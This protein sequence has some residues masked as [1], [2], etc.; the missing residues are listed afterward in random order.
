MIQIVCICDCSPSIVES[1]TFLS[2]SFP[3]FFYL[4]SCISSFVQNKEVVL[5]KKKERSMMVL[6]TRA[7]AAAALTF[8]ALLRETTAFQGQKAFGLTRPT[9]SLSRLDC[10]RCVV[11][12]S[13][14][15]GLV[16]EACGW[17]S[18]NGE[19][20]V[21]GAR[22]ARILSPMAVA[23]AT[24]LS[25]I[26]SAMAA[27]GTFDQSL[28][29]YFPSAL[30]SRKV[31]SKVI[32]TLRDRGFKWDNTV[33]ASSVCSDEINVINES[34]KCLVNELQ[35]AFGDQSFVLG[36]LG[37][38]PFVGKS[39]LGACVSHVPDEGKLLI[40]FAPHVG[41]SADGVVG[42]IR[43][44]NKAKMSDA[45]GAAIGAYNYISS[46]KGASVFSGDRA[47]DDEEEY[48]I[49]QL[50]KRLDTERIEDLGLDPIAVVTYEMYGIVKDLLAEAIA[51]NPAMATKCSEVALLGGVIINQ[52]DGEDY[53]QPL[54]FQIGKEDFFTEKLKFVDVYDETFGAKPGPKLTSVLGGK[55]KAAR[56]F[57]NI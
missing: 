26:P 40:C 33:F 56:L 52:F 10:F 55:S 35:D 48:I 13:G 47:F 21:V 34:P 29:K 54:S 15:T 53:F 1:D 2:P 8:A 43:R 14:D 32:G 22:E 18:V 45:C 57:T 49:E 50:A 25:G 46:K 42:D 44:K 31:A 38:V 37:G 12:E 4:F 27:D 23:L 5:V 17:T 20:G 28:Q 6:A 11:P 19:T 24:V 16:R 39:G 3:G 7:K 41:L 30:T 36:G 9:D 51:G